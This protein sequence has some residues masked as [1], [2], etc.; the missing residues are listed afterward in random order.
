MRSDTYQQRLSRWTAYL[1]LILAA[2]VS[3]HPH[4]LVSPATQA[5]QMPN[6]FA[7][8]GDD[9]RR[10]LIAQFPQAQFT[11]AQ[12]KVLWNSDWFAFI[13]DDAPA[14]VHPSLWEHEKLNNLHGLFEVT[15]G[16][17][18]L[19]GY[20]LANMTLIR[21]E[22]GWIVVD[23]LVSSEIASQLLAFAFAHLP[24]PDR[25]S[26]VILTH[27]HVD[28]FGGIRGVVDGADVSSGAVPI[29]AP[30]GFMEHAVAENVLAGTAM[31]RRAT[32]QFGHGLAFGPQQGVGS[33]LGKAVSRGTIGLLAPTHIISSTGE[34]QRIDG[35]DF[36][37]QL[38][39]GTEAPAEL[40]F[41]LPAYQ[42][43]G[44]AEVASRTM[45]NV[46]T[47]RGAQSRDALRW[48]KV[49]N[50]TLDLFPQLEVAFGSHHWPLWGSDDVRH[51]I[52]QQR[53]V[54]RYLHDR[55]L[56]LAN[57][58]YTPEEIGRA[59]FFPE[60]LRNDSSTRGYY[61]SLSHNL[62]GVYNYYL[63]YYDGNPVHLQPLENAQRARRYVA[64][65]GGVEKVYAL[66]LAAYE[67]QDYQWVVE[68]LDHVMFSGEAHE[69]ARLL[70]AQAFEQLGFRAEAATWRNAYLVAARELREGIIVAE[71]STQGADII[72]SLPMSL[73]FDSLAV[74][75]QHERLDG[76]QFGIM[77]E[78]TDS[79]EV[80]ALE[81]SNTVLHNTQG[82]VLSKPELT[83]RMSRLDFIAVITGRTTFKRLAEQGR[84]SFT[85][86]LSVLQWLMQHLQHFDPQFPIVTP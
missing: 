57:Q 60:Q 58:G 2:L 65:L 16:I 42:A 10:G 82:R 45:H 41:Y 38:A 63:G 29:Y 79:D 86:D 39:N 19:R 80:W 7:S 75:L 71:T 66:A 33:G 11:D 61:G 14:T 5:Q 73:L 22:T 50:E 72:A 67:E 54:Y 6:N 24:G 35:V 32:Y 27:S 8:A 31:T 48:S 84:F 46:Y 68:L 70:Q 34:Q 51:F 4:A 1:M 30:L 77:F 37:F 64:S 74:R 12:G 13:E 69:P 83:L 17:Y 52:R 85:G 21:G 44:Y 3:D 78:M 26:A 55:A 36:V 43:F 40:M 76:R 47:I 28:H 18:Q 20:D 56:S 59:E 53:D 9:A 81:L 23:T 25:V 49:L 62:R 15:D